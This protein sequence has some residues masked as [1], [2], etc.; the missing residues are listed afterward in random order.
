M[1]ESNP[2]ARP[3]IA[4]SILDVIGATPL[5]RLGRLGKEKGVVANIL[6]KLESMEPCSSVK[7]RIAKSLVE[8]AEVFYNLI[9]CVSIVSGKR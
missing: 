2:L 6:L 3:L 1:T 9:D 4:N 7:D 5:V 8:S